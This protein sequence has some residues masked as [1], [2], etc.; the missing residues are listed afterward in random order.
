MQHKVV[1]NRVTS[2]IIGG[3]RTRKK[4]VGEKT[5]S[6]SNTLLTD[7]K[8]SINPM[9][10][11]R[12]TVT[13]D[14]GRYWKWVCSIKW[15]RRMPKAMTH[16]TKNIDNEL[17]FSASTA[18]WVIGGATVVVVVVVVVVVELVVVSG[19]W[20]V[21]LMLSVALLKVTLD[22]DGSITASAVLVTSEGLTSLSD[23][24][25]IGFTKIKIKINKLHT[26]IHFITITFE[27]IYGFWVSG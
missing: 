6:R 2:K 25:A 23:C 20:E 13:I 9:R 10:A 19:A 21:T 17:P 11:P 15:I 4:A 12:Q 27:T 8:F 1:S 5:S 7:V 18:F 14:S 24:D 3:K 22:A 26:E 16:K